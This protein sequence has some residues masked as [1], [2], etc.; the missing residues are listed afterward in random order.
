S[1][2]S[3]DSQL[4]AIIILDSVVVTATK[5][6]FSVEDFIALV[7]S[8]KSFYQAFRNLRFTSYRMKTKMHFKDR[9]GRET[10]DYQALH[11]Q[12][13]DGFCR[14][15][16][17]LSE[18]KTGNLLKRNG[19]FRFY[20]A[21]LHD[22]LFITHDT[23]CTSIDLHTQLEIQDGSGMEGHIG[24]LKKLIFSPG[25]PSDVPLIGRK[26]AIFTKKMMTKYDFFIRSE[27]YLD[28]QEA[29]VFEARLK[30]EFQ[31]GHFNQTVIKQLITYFSKSD[32]QVLGR[33]YRLA[34]RKAL[35]QFDVS[36]QIQLTQHGAFYFPISIIYDGNWGIPTKKREIGTFALDFSEF[37]LNLQ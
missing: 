14:S 35:Y 21:K 13:Y 15:M 16:Q 4:A 2:E 22:R 34:Q 6:A 32:F 17:V 8:D 9:K 33:V 18:S 27:S 28:K 31:D 7:Q 5:G 20:T 36:M 12:N 30:P 23:V 24:E 29:Y 25:E 19:A 1:Q 26:T 10:A 11:Q 3:I 37:E